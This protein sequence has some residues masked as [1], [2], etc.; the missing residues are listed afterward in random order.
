M[1]S[2]L[3][4]T[5]LIYEISRKIGC[6]RRYA[7]MAAFLFF[8]APSIFGEA[9]STHVDQFATLWLLIFLYYYTELMQEDCLHNDK[10]TIQNC[11]I[12]AIC[13][14]FGYLAK[15]SVLIGMALLLVVLLVQCIK[16]KRF[17]YYNREIAFVGNSFNV[18]IF[19]CQSFIEICS[20]FR[21]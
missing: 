13:I 9:L 18:F 17:A 4:N 8:S 3:M 7:Y 14:A 10:N 20:H 15:P 16:K 21:P 12:M 6:G 1:F 11:V 2:T 19:Y 5:W